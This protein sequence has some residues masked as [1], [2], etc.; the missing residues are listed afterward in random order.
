MELTPVIAVG[1]VVALVGFELLHRVRER[2]G[3]TGG[4][5]ADHAWKWVVPAFVLLVVAAE[6]RTLASIGWRVE[7]TLLLVWQVAVGLAAMLG[8]NMLLAPLWSRVGDG[9]QSLAEGI[10]SFASLSVSERLF[11][12]V[13]AGVTEEIPYHGY[14]VER[15]AALTGSVPLAGVVSFAAFTLGHLGET[16]DRQAV[17]RIAQP[18]LVTTLLYLW[19]RSLPALIAIHALNDA[20]GLLVADRYAPEPTEES[21][22]SAA[23]SWL[24]E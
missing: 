10:G 11:V 18:A 15:L 6:G 8:T 5:M 22:S 19:F 17:L 24:D 12:A 16:W 9:G 21:E 23:T 20:F 2:F 1:L 7:S 14:A 13:T 4:P 3:W